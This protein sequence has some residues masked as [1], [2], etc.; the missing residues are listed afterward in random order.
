V[1]IPISAKVE[2]MDNLNIKGIESDEPA[3]PRRSKKRGRKKFVVQFRF[4]SWAT[5]EPTPWYTHSRYHTESARDEAHAALVRNVENC[6]WDKRE[7]RIPE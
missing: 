5:R 1:N 3:K 7:F 4:P 6:W 2:T